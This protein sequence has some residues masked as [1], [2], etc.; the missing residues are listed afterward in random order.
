M[1]AQK[2]EILKRAIKENVEL[3]DILQ[4]TNAILK[5]MVT[6]ELKKENPANYEFKQGNDYLAHLKV[7][8][9]LNERINFNEVEIG[10][11]G[12]QYVEWC[13][14]LEEDK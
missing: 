7:I 4:R 13:K 6:E 11:L 3:S 1:N 10:V 14:Q 12:K 9:Q 2:K 8:H 5:N